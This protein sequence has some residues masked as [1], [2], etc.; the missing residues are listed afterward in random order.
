MGTATV[1]YVAELLEKAFPLKAMMGFGSGL[2]VRATEPVRPGDTINVEQ[3]K[4]SNK[5]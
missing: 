1:A 5:N 2:E 3:A 4:D